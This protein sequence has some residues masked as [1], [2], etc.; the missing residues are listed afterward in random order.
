MADKGSC[1]VITFKY[2]FDESYNPVYA[3]GAYGGLNLGNKEVVMNFFHE[4]GPL[5]RETKV[6][7]DSEG[8][9]EV[10]GSIP[11]SPKTI[12]Y[13]TTGVTMSIEA[14]KSFHM[15]LGTLL[16]EA[17]KNEKQRINDN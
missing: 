3:N 12:R 7:F 2:V 11:E 8:N 16:Q 10:V 14:A 4:R 6:Q 15:W 17:E 1:Q 9:A 5:P 13:I